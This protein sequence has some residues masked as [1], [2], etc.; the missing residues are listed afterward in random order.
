MTRRFP[1]SRF[2][3][4]NTVITRREPTTSTYTRSS[5]DGTRTAQDVQFG[6]SSA[7]KLSFIAPDSARAALQQRQPSQLPESWPTLI[8][9]PWR[10]LWLFGPAGQLGPDIAQP[11][12][13]PARSISHP[14]APPGRIAD[15]LPAVLF[16]K[17]LGIAG[18]L[19]HDRALG[20]ES[21]PA[22][23]PAGL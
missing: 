10:S 16:A 19:A 13:H 11:A 7:I 8:A 9:C 23:R 22:R 15:D 14:S 21:D 5:V 18:A 12:P 3:G 17:G 2:V 1:F 20:Q 6:L 4:G